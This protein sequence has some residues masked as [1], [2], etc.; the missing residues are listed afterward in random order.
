MKTAIVTGA[1]GFVGG[2]LV[3]ELLHHD[4]TVFAV[5]LAGHRENLPDD[6]MVSFVPLE[7]AQIEKLAHKVPEQ[8]V[9]DLPVQI[10]RY[11]F[12]MHNGQ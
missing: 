11:S 9:R 3:R 12:R 7:L 10:P 2:A 5:D 6:D 4:Y 1:N 8:G